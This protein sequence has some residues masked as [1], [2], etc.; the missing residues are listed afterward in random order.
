[1]SEPNTHAAGEDVS[2]EEMV[3]TVAGQTDSASE[4]A[5]VAGRDWDG[6]PSAA[7]APSDEA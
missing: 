3:E 4:N 6:D 2:D 5:D 7:P 1:M